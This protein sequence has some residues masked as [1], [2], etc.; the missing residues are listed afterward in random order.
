MYSGNHPLGIILIECERAGSDARPH[1]HARERAGSD[2]RP[3]SHA[4]GLLV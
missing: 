4:C 3:H 2:A 1:S